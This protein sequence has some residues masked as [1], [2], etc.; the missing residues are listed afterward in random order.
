MQFFASPSV[1]GLHFTVYAPASQ[2]WPGTRAGCFEEFATGVVKI[3]MFSTIL[4]LIRPKKVFLKDFGL[5][6]FGPHGPKTAH[7]S[8]TD[9]LSTEL[10]ATE[11]ETEAA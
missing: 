2:V 4:I 11:A 9:V 6:D 7:G 5:Q 3:Q 10:T 8:E 1:H